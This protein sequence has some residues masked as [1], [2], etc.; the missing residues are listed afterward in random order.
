MR[1]PTTLGLIL[2]VALVPAVYAADQPEELDF[3]VPA[4]DMLS[5]VQHPGAGPMDVGTDG[6]V[7]FQVYT[8][9]A[10]ERYYSIAVSQ[11]GNLTRF[12]SPAAGN[13]LML[14]ME[15]YLACSTNPAGVTA[16]AYEYGGESYG[17][18]SAALWGAPIV[19]D[20]SPLT[21]V[22]STTD[23][24]LQLTQKFAVDKTEVDF[25]ITMTLKNISGQPLSNVRLERAAHVDPDG[26][27]CDDFASKNGIRT[28]IFET[29]GLALDA[30]SSVGTVSTYLV[31][32]FPASFFNTCGA[33]SLVGPLTG[34][35]RSM[36]VQYNFGN[37]NN[38]SSKTVKFRYS[39]L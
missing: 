11:Q 27:C 10:G 21:I 39:R 6:N 14:Y 1:T 13:S 3:G 7:P 4:S 24:R 28:Y 25:T 33:A 30:L 37:M 32:S 29:R 23:S 17:G 9:N 31:A 2:S 20:L 26:D 18:S 34:A 19:T 5:V 8:G 16:T 35:D 36:K 15:G 12:V 38:G 22:R